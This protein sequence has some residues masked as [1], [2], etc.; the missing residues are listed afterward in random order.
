MAQFV[1]RNIED[2]VRDKIRELA[3]NEGKSMEE[4]VREILRNAVAIKQKPRKG[5]GSIFKENFSLCGL[6][7]E[8]SELRGQD[9]QAPSFDE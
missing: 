3:K 7:E 5:L 4:V 2:N 1:V 8:I 6:E 9:V